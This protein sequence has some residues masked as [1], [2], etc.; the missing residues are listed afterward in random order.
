MWLLT[1][2]VQKIISGQAVQVPV[3][4][5]KTHSRV[6]GEVVVIQVEA[7]VVVMMMV[8]SVPRPGTRWWWWRAY[9]CSTSPGSGACSTSSSSWTR[10]RTPA[11]RGQQDSH[12]YDDSCGHLTGLLPR[13]PLIRANCG[14]CQQVLTRDVSLTDDNLGRERGTVL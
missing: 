2:S 6:V 10:T 8:T 5:F 1:N 13:S 7:E 14:G 9:W 12:S 3:Y 4:D 11:S